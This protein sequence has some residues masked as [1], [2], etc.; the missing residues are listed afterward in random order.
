MRKLWRSLLFVFLCLSLSGQLAAQ[1]ISENDSLLI[2]H[3]QLVNEQVALLKNRLAQAKH[4]LTELQTRSNSRIP[5]DQ[6]STQLLKQV[7]LDIAVAKSNLDSVDIELTE[8]QQTTARI[9]KHMQDIENQLNILNIFGL[10]IARSSSSPNVAALES[11]LD[12]QRAL[13]DVED[14]RLD[15]LLQL[16]TVDTKIYELYKEKYRR[17]EQMLKSQTILRL[18][19][20]QEKSEVGFQRQQTYWLSQ[21]NNLYA[22]LNRVETS[23]TSDKSQVAELESEIFFANENVNFTYLQMLMARYEDQIRQYK[24]SIARSTSIDML[25][26]MSEQ[27]QLLVK[28]LVRVE[29][30]LKTRVDILEKREAFLSH[31][32]TE[33]AKNHADLDVLNT[34]KSQYDDSLTKVATLNEQ[35][36]VLRNSLDLALHQELSARQSLPG[37]GN[38][39][40][41]DLGQ[42]LLWVPKLAYQMSKS[43]LTS[44]VQSIDEIGYEWGGLF[45]LF[46]IL[47]LGGIYFL[48]R[49]FTKTVSSMDDHEAGHIN[50]KWLIIKLFHHNL[51]EMALLMNAV[52]FFIL[53]DLPAQ[54]YMF[55]IDVGIVWLLFKMAIT[56]A[57]LVIVESV[58]DHTTNVR[59]YH[60]YRFVLIVGGIL[61]AMSVFVSQLPIVY[62]VKDLFDRLFLLYTLLISIFLL[63]SC[64][65]IPVLLAPYIDERRTY[66]KRVINLLSLFIPLILLSS[67]IIGLIGYVNMVLTISWYESVFLWVT[68][69]YLILRGLLIEMMAQ[70][71]Y[72][73]IRHVTNGW[74]W[75]EAFLK[76]LDKV[77]RITLFLA[78][79]SVLFLCYGWDQ[80]SPVVERLNKLMHYSLV[81]VLNTT[82]TPLSVIEVAVI[83]SLLF[84]AARWT[85][86]FVYRFL[87]SRTKDIGLRNSIAILSQYTMVVI[88]VLII[89]RVLGIDFRALTV[90]AGMFFFGVGLGLRDL[91]NNFAC[92]FL[93]LIER[94]IRVGDII[95]INGIEGDVVHIGSRAVTVR[96]FD[97][98]DLL[99]PNAEIF[100]K[101]FI[102]WT[103][104]DNI[105][106][107]VVPIKINRY[108]N[109]HEIQKLIYDVLADHK[110]VLKDPEPEV[111][112]KEMLEEIEFEVRYYINIRQVKS[113][114]SIRSEVLTKIWDIFEQHKIKPP[115]P[116]H[117]IV[118]KDRSLF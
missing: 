29:T 79:W 12:Y 34:L 10:K 39:A 114:V 99:V 69:G 115:Y 105:V 23:K 70:A 117:E 51:V 2:D 43:L 47:W 40:W 33:T 36:G 20:E 48:D 28:Q 42:Q 109:P 38:S 76:P 25:N 73:L 113:R 54:S 89:L 104:K 15:Y 110:A 92:G 21:L 72:I 66:V 85:R 74:L 9:D 13:Y 41:L 118:V 61:T 11:E 46:E 106:R 78:A 53:C 50:P 108:D 32:P 88:G 81:N 56:T 86:E 31:T 102:N 68:V 94:P 62:E 103:G 22:Q 58:H 44:V 35:L 90:V 75:T 107:T 16:Q 67:S 96:T 60:R 6:V 4:Q 37:F 64:R 14:T 83:I 91:F 71:S 116:H 97:H 101:S 26:K 3:A 18:K 111:L 8:A 82:I 27:T 52:I 19:E 84:W 1:T 49:Y 65:I 55:I 63:K 93:L 112:M 59:L 17:I 57:R 24:I 100:S 95:V 98:M 80:Q 77:L 5:F 45:V 87:L 30:L 7:G